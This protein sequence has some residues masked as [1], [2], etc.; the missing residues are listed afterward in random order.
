MIYVTFG[1]I[2]LCFLCMVCFVQCKRRWMIIRYE[3]LPVTEEYKTNFDYKPTPG[4]LLD[5]EY[6]NT[7]VGVSMPILHE[8]TK[9]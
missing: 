2:L 4:G 7:F 9:V 5:E 3:R 1:L 6:E 8:V